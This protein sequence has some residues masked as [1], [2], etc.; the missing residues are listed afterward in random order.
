MI[1]FEKLLM[2]WKHILSLLTLASRS[3]I[4]FEVERNGLRKG[5]S[6]LDSF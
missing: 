1:Q 3:L 5:K 4:K 6:P 2:I